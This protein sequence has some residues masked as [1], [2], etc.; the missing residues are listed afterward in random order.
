MSNH[1]KRDKVIKKL[2]EIQSE[3]LLIG[4]NGIIAKYHPDVNIDDPDAAQVF[5]LY[6]TVHEN[7]KQR[8]T[9]NSEHY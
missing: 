8:I 1:V 7:M 2:N 3:I 6:K 4:W 9:I 5:Q